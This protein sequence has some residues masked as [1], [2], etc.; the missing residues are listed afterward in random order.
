MHLALTSS[1]ATVSAATSLSFVSPKV[2][3]VGYTKHV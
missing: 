3:N 1:V 2:L